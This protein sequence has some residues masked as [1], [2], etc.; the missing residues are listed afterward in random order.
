M[1]SF[2]MLKAGKEHKLWRAK[3]IFQDM[4]YFQ[5]TCIKHTFQAAGHVV[6]LTYSIWSVWENF[7][8]F[9][10]V[11]WNIQFFKGKTKETY[12]QETGGKYWN[13][14]ITKKSS[15]SICRT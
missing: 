12:E 4:F 14:I 6:W 13:K 1:C 9:H 5:Q 8:I 7:S 3:V 11:A 2:S 15:N 10:K